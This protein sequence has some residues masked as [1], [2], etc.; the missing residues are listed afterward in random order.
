MLTVCFNEKGNTVISVSIGFTVCCPK[1]P[2]DLPWGFVVHDVNKS[3]LILFSRK[4]NF[5]FVLSFFRAAPAA[6]GGS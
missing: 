6:Y 1:F 5:V 3:H 2:P 4:N